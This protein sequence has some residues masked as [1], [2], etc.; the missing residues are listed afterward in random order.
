M[1]N[2]YS[3]WE[4]SQGPTLYIDSSGFESID[5]NKNFIYF[6][7]VT[8]S[9]VEYKRKVTDETGTS[10]YEYKYS[11]GTDNSSRKILDRYTFSGKNQ[12]TKTVTHTVTEDGHKDTISKT[13]I[14]DTNI[15]SNLDTNIHIVVN[16]TLV[17][18]ISNWKF[19]TTSSV[20]IPQAFN[21]TPR[22][23]VTVTKTGY[24]TCS[25][26]SYGSSTSWNGTGATVT[27]PPSTWSSRSY[28]GR[29]ARTS[30][31]YYD[32]AI[33]Q[34]E[35]DKYTYWKYNGN[36][37]RSENDGGNVYKKESYTYSYTS[38]YTKTYNYKET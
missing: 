28:S 21:G 10:T 25:Y 19:N 5:D 22:G 23:W 11:F 29:M 14:I 32:G 26:T 12:L 20:K 13:F 16:P 33:K 9:P 6:Y 4:Y 37:Y 24:R 3:S 1:A 2:T 36:D 15:A 17:A 7:I 35:T 27:D 34:Y 31:G 18:Q 30:I 38:N 8:Y